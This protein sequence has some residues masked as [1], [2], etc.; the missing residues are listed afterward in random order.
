MQKC[1]HQAIK[2]RSVKYSKDVEA[3]WTWFYECDNCMFAPW[4]KDITR[5]REETLDNQHLRSAMGLISM[6]SL[7]VQS[8]TFHLVSPIHLIIVNYY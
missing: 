2:E 3:T 6:T 7:Y 1:C 5:I 8:I 4:F